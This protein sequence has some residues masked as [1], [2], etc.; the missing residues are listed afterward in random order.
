MV[1]RKRRMGVISINGAEEKD[2]RGERK[3]GG[4]WAARLPGLGVPEDAEEEKLH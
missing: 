2:K 1:E 4:R 3:G